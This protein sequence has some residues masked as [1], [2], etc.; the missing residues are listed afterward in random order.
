MSLDDKLREILNS[1]FDPAN[2]KGSQDFD[3][4]LITEIKQAFADYGYVPVATLKDKNMALSA[5]DG[6]YYE[7]MTG[8]EFYDRFCD[9]A[10][11]EASSPTEAIT[12]MKAMLAAKRAA[13]LE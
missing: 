6:K 7:L 1:P 12:I 13:G 10:A 5:N 3:S 9:E 2:F 4:Q 11:G 8:Q